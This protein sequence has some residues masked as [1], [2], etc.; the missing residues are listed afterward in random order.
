[1]GISG[2]GAWGGIGRWPWTLGN[3]HRLSQ[4]QSVQAAGAAGLDGE[5]ARTR[6]TPTN[7]C[8]QTH[9]HQARP[10]PLAAGSLTDDTGMVGV[11]PPIHALLQ[12][13]QERLCLR[14]TSTARE[15]Q[16]LVSE[17]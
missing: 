13:L 15:R 9:P 5:G 16:K 8:V 11:Q 1:M 2:G 4:H 14:S 3:H 17:L 6:L 10:A 12:L 7:T